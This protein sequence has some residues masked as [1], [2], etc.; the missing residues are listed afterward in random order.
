LKEGYRSFKDT[1]FK[2]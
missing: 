2:A 1:N